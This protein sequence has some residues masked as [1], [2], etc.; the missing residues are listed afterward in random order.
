MSLRLQT[1]MDS[2][3]NVYMGSPTKVDES[4]RTYNFR[5][6]F[7]FTKD[8]NIQSQQKTRK[9]RFTKCSVGLGQFLCFCPTKKD[10]RSLVSQNSPVSHEMFMFIDFASGQI[11]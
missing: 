6:V 3:T 1:S 7:N 5:S 8:K 11:G 10:L 2:P 4:F 9:K